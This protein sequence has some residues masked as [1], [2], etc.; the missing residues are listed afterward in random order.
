MTLDRE[1]PL[2]VLDQLR[3]VFDVETNIIADVSAFLERVNFSTTAL[4]NVIVR[5]QVSGANI[6]S[7]AVPQVRDVI[8]MEDGRL[9]PGEN[10][11]AIN[12]DHTP[13]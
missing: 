10:R 2:Q 3:K 1:E 12:M 7:D 6:F 11:P 8:M 13:S 4:D 5:H 9:L